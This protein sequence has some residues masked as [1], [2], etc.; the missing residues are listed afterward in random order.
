MY[1]THLWLKQ[2]YQRIS[3]WYSQHMLLARYIENMWATRLNIVHVI[4]VFNIN[5]RT[6]LFLPWV[7]ETFHAR[8]FSW[9]RRWWWR[10]RTKSTNA[11]QKTYGIEGTLSSEWTSSIH[12]LLV[13]AA[14]CFV[15]PLL[16]FDTFIHIYSGWAYS[17]GGTHT[18]LKSNG[19]NLTNPIIYCWIINNIL[20]LN[21]SL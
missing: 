10:R 11:R 7:P 20:G 9:L 14:S 13:I 3:H 16:P 4:S 8:F 12:C 2:I 19:F 6:A 21:I 15:H 17:K 5:K 1:G 18:I